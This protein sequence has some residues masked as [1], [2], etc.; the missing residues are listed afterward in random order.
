MSKAVAGHDV[1]AKDVAKVSEISHLV[2]QDPVPW[3]RKKNLRAL[4]FTL[5]PAA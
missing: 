2:A 1:A 5:I 3:Y 4:Y